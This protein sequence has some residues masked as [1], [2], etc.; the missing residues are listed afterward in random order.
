MYQQLAIRLIRCV[1][2]RP[3]TGITG[4]P[5]DFRRGNVVSIDAIREDSG[6]FQDYMAA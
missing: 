2:P 3:L 1:E 5:K 4:A 6:L